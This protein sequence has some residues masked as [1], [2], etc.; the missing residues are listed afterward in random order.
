MS[1]FILY[2]YNNI[3]IFDKLVFFKQIWSLLLNKYSL[4][5]ILTKFKKLHYLK[6]FSLK[7]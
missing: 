2:M 5:K 6:N 7:K 3:K 1:F 4:I